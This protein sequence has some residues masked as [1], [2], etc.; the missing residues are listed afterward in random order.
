[1][2]CVNYLHVYWLHKFPFMFMFMIELQYECRTIAPHSFPPCSLLKFFHPSNLFPCSS[3]LLITCL[4]YQIYSHMWAAGRPSYSH[5]WAAGRP[6]YSHVWAA[7]R[8]SYLSEISD[9]LPRV[10]CWA[11]LLPVWDT[12]TCGLLGVPLTCLRYQIY[13]HVSAVGRLV[14]SCWETRERNRKQKPSSPERT[15]VVSSDPRCTY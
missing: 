5:V 15:R 8:P 2:T 11:S 1:M 9:I 10:G 6:S 14:A 7:G 12:P 3:L 13:S 4:R